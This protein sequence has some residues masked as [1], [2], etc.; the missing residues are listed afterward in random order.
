MAEIVPP[1]TVLRP[2]GTPL[3]RSATWDYPPMRVFAFAT[4]GGVPFAKMSFD[5]AASGG[6]REIPP[7]PRSVP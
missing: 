4:T 5:R 3:V 1:T 6:K 2:T 7:L